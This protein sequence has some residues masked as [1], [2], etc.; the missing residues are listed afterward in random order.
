M[1]DDKKDD[2][3]GFRDF[4]EGD[5]LLKNA[6]QP[7][8]KHKRDG[9]EMFSFLELESKRLDKQLK[10]LEEASYLLKSCDSFPGLNKQINR[11]ILLTNAKLMNRLFDEDSPMCK[12]LDEVF[13]D[14]F[15]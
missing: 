4:I 10:V 9:F 11:E 8:K 2:L 3:I 7:N 15:G 13:K 14:L 1:S 12:S 5:K 6:N